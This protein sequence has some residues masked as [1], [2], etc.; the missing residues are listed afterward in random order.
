MGLPAF[1]RSQE[2]AG[3][4]CWRL[5]ITAEPRAGSQEEPTAGKGGHDHTNTGSKC[6][7]EYVPR[8]LVQSK[9]G[10]GSHI[11]NF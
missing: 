9:W 7:Q 10:A 11:S 4:F 8:A 3:F 5:Y 6:P 1:A 2:K